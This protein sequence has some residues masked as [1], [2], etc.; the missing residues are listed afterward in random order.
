LAAGM[1]L[2]ML[3]A[4]MH[5]HPVTLVFLVSVDSGLLVQHSAL[6]VVRHGVYLE[7]VELSWARVSYSCWVFVAC[8]CCL[9]E[10]CP[11]SCHVSCAVLCCVAPADAAVRQPTLKGLLLHSTVCCSLPAG[12]CVLSSSCCAGLRNVPMTAH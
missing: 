1:G 8:F 6:H 2:Y 7:W 5:T 4:C 10:S 3:W 12:A 9:V 11:C